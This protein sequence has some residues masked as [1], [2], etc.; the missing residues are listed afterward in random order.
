MA[1]PEP[2][3]T[4]ALKKS[5]QQARQS[6]TT[7]V[8]V[9]FGKIRQ[10]KDKRLLEVFLSDMK[11]VRSI[12]CKWDDRVNMV[13]SSGEKENRHC[14]KSTVEEILASS[15]APQ[16]ST[17]AAASPAPAPAAK[18]A[19]SAQKPAAAYHEE[20]AVR[21]FQA[22]SRETASN[23]LRPVQKGPEILFEQVPGRQVHQ[24]AAVTPD[25]QST[26]SAAGGA[27]SLPME[28]RDRIR[29]ATFQKPPR[30]PSPSTPSTAR[31]TK[32]RRASRPTAAGN[33]LLERVVV[34]LDLKRFPPGFRYGEA[35]EQLA[36][37]W[38]EFNE[39]VGS[40]KHRI[41]SVSHLEHRLPRM[42]SEKLTLL[43]ELLESRGFLRARLGEGSVYWERA[44]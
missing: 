12:I 41:V 25:L 42:G 17:Q 24:T 11:L 34:P 43:L 29:P 31:A 44:T 5:C 9:L 16:D 19:R 36:A 8:D 15:A 3:D 35:A 1:A 2:A 7:Q 28:H 38:G 23:N 21:L 39:E 6:L 20:R 14:F 26:K 33:P 10:L 13:L 27:A 18:K 37:V 32:L 22:S 30:D 4:P 40:R